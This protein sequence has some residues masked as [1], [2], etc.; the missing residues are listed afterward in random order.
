MAAA[1]CAGGGGGGGS[2]VAGMPEER[3]E[4]GSGGNERR[5]VASRPEVWSRGWRGSA[6]GWWGARSSAARGR[7]PKGGVVGAALVSS[8]F[9]D[10]RGLSPL[11]T[12][13]P[14]PRA[15]G[16]TRVGPAGRCTCESATARA[17]FRGECPHGGQAAACRVGRRHSWV[18]CPVADGHGTPDGAVDR[19]AR[20][21]G[22]YRQHH[23]DPVS[24]VVA[25]RSIVHP[26]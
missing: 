9:G 14:P 1:H 8:S 15:F 22:M 16:L 2:H 25:L 26:Q 11:G 18:T 7:P 20:G 5:E 21:R 12:G 19:R 4:G 24:S 13:A 10:Q 23:A 17:V 6:P 3:G